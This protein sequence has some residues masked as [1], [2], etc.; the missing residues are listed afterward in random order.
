[1]PTRVVLDESPSAMQREPSSSHLQQHGVFR[2]TLMRSVINTE[3]DPNSIRTAVYTS[4]SDIR[5]SPRLAG[6]IYILIASVVMIASVAQFYKNENFGTEIFKRLGY[7]DRGDFIIVGG[8]RVYRWK[9]IGAFVVACTGAVSALFVLLVHFDPFCAPNF[10]KKCFRDGS[11][12]ERNFLIVNCVFWGAGVHICTSSF[13]IGTNQPNVFFTTW[14]A[15]IASALNYD[16]WRLGADLP[17]LTEFVSRQRQTTIYNWSWTFVFT[18]ITAGALT[19]MYVNREHYL[20]YQDG[21][22][23]RPPIQDWVRALSVSWSFV[24]IAS[25]SIYAKVMFVTWR[26]QWSYVEGVVIA[27]LIGL[28]AW[29]CTTYT[30]VQG[31]VAGPTNAYF[32]IWGVFFSN[33]AT[34][35]TWLRETNGVS[36][37]RRRITSSISSRLDVESPRSQRSGGDQA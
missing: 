6:Y 16:M 37:I 9:F 28:T 17:C 1:M 5:A 23:Y 24:G 18:I 35:G 19:D 7:D 36:H 34:F 10:W 14:I 30:G 33:L 25:F 21:T 2:S 32:G 4:A 20:L 31:A 27:T 22:P 29:A 8:S 3:A 26:K 12:Y 13:S 15:F 11:K